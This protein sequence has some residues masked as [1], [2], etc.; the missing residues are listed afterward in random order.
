MSATEW[1]EGGAEAFS[2]TRNSNLGKV[3]GNAGKAGGVRACEF[4][5][6]RADT[7]RQELDMNATV[8][9]LPD[10]HLAY[11]RHVGPYGAAGGI[12]ALWQE[13]AR[14]AKAHDLWNDDALLVGVARDNPMITDPE[15][16]RYDAGIVVPEGFVPS[17][18]VNVTHLPGGKCA[19][20]TFRGAARE[21][22]RGWQDFFGSWLP[23][24][25]YQPDDRPCFELYR[26]T[27]TV[28]PATGVFTCELG[29]PVRPL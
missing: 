1:R 19:I 14:W 8:K 2:R 10:Y 18:R 25:G 17:G 9:T 24:S 12:P 11:L 22:E 20:L 27:E 21:I 15:R 23:G 4:N 6:V 28:D 3:N 16:L 5:P 26:T 7:A 13:F 29:I